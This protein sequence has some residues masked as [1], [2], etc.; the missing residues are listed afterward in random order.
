MI[1]KFKQV[2]LREKNFLTERIPFLYYNKNLNN[3]Y[4]IS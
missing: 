1:N 3:K 2:F 4:E